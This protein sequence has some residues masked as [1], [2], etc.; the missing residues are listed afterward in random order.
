MP[1]ARRRPTERQ[2][3]VRDSDSPGEKWVL[4]ENAAGVAFFAFGALVPLLVAAVSIYGLV[5]DPTD[6]GT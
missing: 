3:T 1:S 5:S 4:T 6:I 2:L